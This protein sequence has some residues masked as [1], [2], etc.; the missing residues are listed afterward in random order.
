MNDLLNTLCIH[1]QIL[2]KVNFRFDA[3]F[4]IAEIE[5]IICAFN[6]TIFRSPRWCA[7]PFAYKINNSPDRIYSVEFSI[8]CGEGKYL[9]YKL[10]LSETQSEYYKYKCL[11]K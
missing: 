7:N 11:I 3:A 4:C 5:K 9:S 2:L 10:C 1:F 6:E 8:S